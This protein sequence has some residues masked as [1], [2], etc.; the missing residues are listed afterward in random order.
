VDA[1]VEELVKLLCEDFAYKGHELSGDLI[2][3]YVESNRMEVKC[4][5]CGVVSSKVHSLYERRFRDLPIQGK[6]TEIVLKNR[7]YFC[8]NGNCPNRT[9][10]ESFDCLPYKG[11]RSKRLTEAIIE[12][13]L[14]TS[15]LTAAATLRKGVADVGKTTICDLLK[16]GPP[17]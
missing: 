12:I 6:K 3:I 5:Y 17:N 15:S 4:P 8:Y 9:F 11:K 13:A 2:W 10:A 16:K 7:N 1:T 14:N